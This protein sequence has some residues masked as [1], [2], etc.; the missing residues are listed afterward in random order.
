[1]GSEREELSKAIEAFQNH[2]GLFN[3]LT[4][5]DI[6][7]ILS[8]GRGCTYHY[9][10]LVSLQSNLLNSEQKV[11]NQTFCPSLRVISEK[12]IEEVL[13]EIQYEFIDI[14]ETFL[15]DD[16]SECEL[17]FSVYGQAYLFKYIDSSYHE[18]NYSLVNFKK[19]KTTTKTITV[20]EAV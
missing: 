13:E 17:V 5:K 4:Q 11:Y 7:G 9:K 8:T 1:M 16:S 6:L 18:P 14:K 3:C 12:I 15:E 19:C 2:K 20:W 10:V